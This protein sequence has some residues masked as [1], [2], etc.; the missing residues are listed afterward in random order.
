MK[1]LIALALCGALVLSLASCGGQTGE[2]RDD[3]PPASAAASAPTTAPTQMP[4]ADFQATIEETVLV[5]EKDV[6]ITATESTPANGACSRC[7]LMTCW[8]WRFGRP[9]DWML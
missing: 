9:T 2:E 3:N 5:D 4:D 7:S 6:K 1:K 8:I